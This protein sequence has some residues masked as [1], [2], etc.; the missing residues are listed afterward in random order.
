[1]NLAGLDK[2]TFENNTAYINGWLQALN[3]DKK[4]IVIAASQAEKAVNWIKGMK[5]VEDNN[6]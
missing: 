2:V 1:M 6:L 4:M 5:D 3:K